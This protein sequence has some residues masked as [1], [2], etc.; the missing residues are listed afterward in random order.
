MLQHNICSRCRMPHPGRLG[1]CRSCKESDLEAARRER[2][3]NL[4]TLLDSRKTRC[5]CP[6]L[7]NQTLHMF[8]CI[9]F[10]SR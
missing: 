3:K 7:R 5:G 9:R 4:S 10:G 1:L 8:G 6:R 2:E